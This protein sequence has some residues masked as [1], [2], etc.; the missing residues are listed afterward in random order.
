MRQ[1][2]GVVFDRVGGRC[3]VDSG[4]LLLPTLAAVMLHEGPPWVD[5]AGRAIRLVTEGADILHGPGALSPSVPVDSPI[6]VCCRPPL[7]PFTPDSASGGVGGC[8][9]SCSLPLLHRRLVLRRRLLG[10]LMRSHRR[11][12]PLYLVIPG[13]ADPGLTP[14]PPLS[15]LPSHNESL[16]LLLG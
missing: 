8:R 10:G 7:S 6:V 13:S 9:R 1:E 15:L 11:P 16:P 2:G 5:F 12:L 4:H 3:D 14:L